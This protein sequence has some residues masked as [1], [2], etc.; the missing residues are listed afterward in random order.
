MLKY[1]ELEMRIAVCLRLKMPSS[2][3][4]NDRPPSWITLLFA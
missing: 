2:V 4:N 1:W 3:W